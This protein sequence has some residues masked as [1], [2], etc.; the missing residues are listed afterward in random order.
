MSETS[1]IIAHE[2]WAREARKARHRLYPVTAL[3]TACCT[4]VLVAGLRSGRAGL[5]LAFYGLGIAAWTLLEYLVHRHILHGRFPDGPSLWEKFLHRTF[6]HLHLE[7][8]KRPWDGNHVNGT[9]K[10]TGPFVALFAGLAAFAP[11]ATAPAFLAGLVQSYV[12]E[13]WVHHSTHFCHF[14]NA[15]FRY[16]K[17]HHLF[18]HSPKGANVAY[19]LSNGFWDIVLDTRIPEEMRARLYRATRHERQSQP[20]TPAFG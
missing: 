19:G 8:H 20:G 5:T 15:Y 17:R 10:D 16:I 12:V 14:D 13:E 7:H 6:D 4:A 2:R 18:H 1:P 9:L 11:I 3:Y